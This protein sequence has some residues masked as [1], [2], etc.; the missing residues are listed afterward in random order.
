MYIPSSMV[1]KP[2]IRATMVHVLCHIILSRRLEKEGGFSLNN[3]QSN[4]VH[5]S[6]LHLVFQRLFLL[7]LVNPSRFLLF[8][9]FST[10]Q[11]QCVYPKTTFSPPNKSASA[12][13]SLPSSLSLSCTLISLK[14]PSFP[15][16][17]PPFHLNPAPPALATILTISQSI[18]ERLHTTKCLPARPQ[19][20]L[21]QTSAMSVIAFA[22]NF[23][24]QPATFDA[25]HASSHI[26]ATPTVPAKKLAPSKPALLLGIP[27]GLMPV[28]RPALKMVDRMQGST[29]VMMRRRPIICVS[30]LQARN[31]HMRRPYPNFWYH[32]AIIRTRIGAAQDSKMLRRAHTMEKEVK[33]VQMACRVG[34]MPRGLWR[35]RERE[36]ERVGRGAG[37]GTGLE[38]RR[39]RSLRCFVGDWSERYLERFWG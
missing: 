15:R 33:V 20:S 37:L 32:A 9:S 18:P 30:D 7:S 35:C 3:S 22:V 36:R 21:P 5:I 12:A 17:S 38:T 10:P 28:I 16:F 4:E 13:L 8:S 11:L 19:H 6:I 31:R 29:V 24:P 14:P 23:L 34:V 39:L 25:F 1:D 26:N 2:A 27:P